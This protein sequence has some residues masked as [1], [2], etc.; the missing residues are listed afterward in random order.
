MKMEEVW[1]V[2]RSSLTLEQKALAAIMVML[3]EDRKH[4]IHPSRGYLCK[5][6]SMS[7]SSV[8]RS[9][10]A[11]REAGVL[12]AVPKGNNGRGWL[13][14]Y[15][16]HPEGLPFEPIEKGSDR[17]VLS[18]KGSTQNPFTDTKGS[19]QTRDSNPESQLNTEISDSC[20]ASEPPYIREVKPYIRESSTGGVAKIDSPSRP[21]GYTKEEN[22]RAD[23]N[24]HQEM[25]TLP[26]MRRTWSERCQLSHRHLNFPKS[27][28]S[29]LLAAESTFDPME[30]RRSWLSF[31]ESDSFD[32]KQFLRGIGFPASFGMGANHHRGTGGGKWSRPQRSF[33]AAP[34]QAKGNYQRETY[35]RRPPRLEGE[36]LIAAVK[37]SYE[38]HNGIGSWNNHGNR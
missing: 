24:L 4:V 27:H 20:D 11:L 36:A 8:K 22:P 17:T 7:E 35:Q 12:V 10:S 37:E 2:W 26:W 9:L 28:I 15:T 5:I 38:K 16:V 34:A 19:T 14:P 25:S 31:L 18:I 29:N 6:C 23:Q 1:K 3:A 33:A 30:F 32:P 13:S 21:S